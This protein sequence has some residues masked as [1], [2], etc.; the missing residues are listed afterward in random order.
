[1]LNNEMDDFS[2]KPGAPNVYGGLGGAANAIAPG[3]TPLSSMS[4][5]IA[6]REGRP[7]MAVGAPG[8][9]RIISCTAETILNLLA[10]RLPPYEAVASVRFHHQ[11]QPDEI[12][13]DAPGPGAEAEAAL[14][15]MGY[16]L[17]VG[18]NAVPCR[19][20]L[21]VREG[22]L[23]RGISDPRDSGSALAN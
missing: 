5:T 11:W 1:V 13:M 10:Y 18:A 14:R 7:V 20:M 15:K 23:L 6:L 4:P 22:E 21:A 19:V 16:K 17:R 9:T 3:K 12:S 2:A 8:G